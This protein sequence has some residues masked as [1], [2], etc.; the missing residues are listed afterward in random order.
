M[1]CPKN[2][3]IVLRRQQSESGE[4]PQADRVVN[5]LEDAIRERPETAIVANPAPFHVP[6]AQALA[7]AGCHLLVEKPLSDSLEGIGQLIET[8]DARK[9]VLMVGYVLR[10]V[11]SLQFMASQIAAGKIGRILHVATEVGQY[12]PD[13]R[14]STNYRNSVTAR[15]SLGGGALLELSHEI[16]IALWI[17]GPAVSVAAGLSR[18]GS[19]EIDTEDCAD[20]RL[21]FANGASGTVHMDLLQRVPVRRCKVVGSEGTLK[22]DYFSDKIKLGRPGAG[23]QTLDSRQLTDSNEMYIDEVSHFMHCVARNAEP[24]ISGRTAVA[25]LAVALAAKKSA[26]SGRAERILKE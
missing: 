13:W 7:E 10:F 16:D 5:T 2:R 25:V 19:L 26:V 1:L 8:C 6:V 21:D 22:W 9:L 18:L 14:P 20:L 11:P 24:A 12:L 3:I 23:W 17:G 15:N 4:L